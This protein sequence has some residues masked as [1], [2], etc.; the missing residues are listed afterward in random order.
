MGRKWNY[1][2]IIKILNALVGMTEPTADS[3]IDEN[4]E[5][6]LKVLI[7]VVNWCLDEMYYSARYRKS[8][9]GSARAIGERAYAAMLEWEGW[10]KNVDENLA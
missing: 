8:P 5:E 6:N 7:D 3:A 1:N 2:E 10:L 4:V 9:Y